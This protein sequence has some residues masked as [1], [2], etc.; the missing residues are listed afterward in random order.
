MKD[1]VVSREDLYRSLLKKSSECCNLR[2]DFIN[3]K[4]GVLEAA[5][6]KVLQDLTPEHFASPEAF[7]KRVIEDLEFSFRVHGV[8]ASGDAAMRHRNN[9]EWC[10]Q[11][12]KDLREAVKATLYL[13]AEADV[14]YRLA[15]DVR[16]ARFPF[17]LPPEE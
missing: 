5:K 10:E 17:N 12:K 4:T 1:E 3:K 6:V 16:M 9:L 2:A 13:D 15:C 11:A 7:E 14:Y 8:T